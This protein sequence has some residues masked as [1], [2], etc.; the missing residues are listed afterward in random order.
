MILLKPPGLTSSKLV[1]HCILK[2][3]KNVR[4]PPKAVTSRCAAN[5]QREEQQCMCSKLTKIT[6]T[7]SV[8]PTEAGLMQHVPPNPLKAKMS[9]CCQAQGL[10]TRT[11]T[12]CCNPRT[13]WSAVCLPFIKPEHCSASKGGGLPSPC[14]CCGPIASR[15]PRCCISAGMPRCG[16]GAR[17]S[18]CGLHPP[19]TTALSLRAQTSPLSG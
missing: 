16:D 3:A 15:A 11:E 17:Q 2:P 9:T 18:P 12:P 6:G 10:Q 7:Q 19:P 14:R 5:T 1:R 13:H 8:A 4:P